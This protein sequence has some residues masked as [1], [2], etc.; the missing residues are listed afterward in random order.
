MEVK[1][2]KLNPNA[3]IPTYSTTGAAGMDVCPVSMEY[4]ED[5][6]TWVYDTG[7]SFELPEGYVMLIFPRSSNRK[8]SAYL[9]NSVGVLDADYRGPLLVCF[10]NRDENMKTPPYKVDGKAI[11]QIIIIPY[12][13]I[14]FTEVDNLSD[15][16]R[17]AGGFG[18]TDGN[19]N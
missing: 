18:S 4:K 15:T 1:I 6:D 9:P 5:I 14:E 7:L 3:V 16:A 10:K 19:N 11:A 8:T 17:G 12:P 13:H 2:K